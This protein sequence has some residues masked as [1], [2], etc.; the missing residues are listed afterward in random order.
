MDDSE[1]AIPADIKVSASE[2]PFEV[3]KLYKD[4]SVYLGKNN[5]Y[6]TQTQQDVVYKIEDEN[7]DF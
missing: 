1:F 2:S 6:P 3:V 5:M 7:W 4:N